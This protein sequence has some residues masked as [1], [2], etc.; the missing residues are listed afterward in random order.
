MGYAVAIPAA[1]A[2]APSRHGIR[3]ESVLLGSASTLVVAG[4]AAG[5]WRGAD[6][7]LLLVLTLLNGLTVAAAW[8]GYRT[9]NALLRLYTFVFLVWYGMRAV[10][11][12]VNPDWHVFVGW[13]WWV[14]DSFTHEDLERTGFVLLVYHAAAVAVLAT[15]GAAA[16]WP[17]FQDITPKLA[18]AMNRFVR[19]VFVL[20]V[21][22]SLYRLATDVFVGVLRDTRG[23]AGIHGY[24]GLFLGADLVT[25]LLWGAVLAYGRVLDRGSRWCAAAFIA[26]YWITNTAN[27]GRGFFV[28]FLLLV[29]IYGVLR[30]RECRLPA[31]GRALVNST[32]LLAVTLIS[33]YIGYGYRRVYRNPDAT[34]S[35]KAVRQELT[36]F[37]PNGAD[38]VKWASWRLSDF[39]MFSMVV[40]RADTRTAHTITLRNTLRAL[41]N[42]AVIG[43]D[44]F[45][46]GDR[47]LWPSSRS[48][49]IDYAGG[50]SRTL[51]PTHTDELGLFATS[52]ST[53]G[54]YSGV[55]VAAATLLLAAFGLAAM[56]RRLPAGVS[57]VGG[58]F[59]AWMFANVVMLPGFDT[60][61]FNA[62]QYFFQFMVLAA[63]LV[64]VKRLSKRRLRRY[65]S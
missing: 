26:I 13:S 63:F 64:V 31:H 19:R 65:A 49:P 2:P 4:L 7:E 5:Y 39:D 50:D 8:W 42:R 25:M 17:S 53:T 51:N 10:T 41:A 23:S 29:G 37:G 18:E 20:F 52:V 62:L 57:A 15:A 44:P 56:T 55:I 27:G 40:L 43:S 59:F 45:T 48:V 60:F 3:V 54:V 21:I 12:L 1:V 6:P 58:L 16:R 24:I 38:L 30:G 34:V 28:K 22:L 61:V 14:L 47:P 11:L 33:I 36:K 9:D 46:D 35:A 32:A